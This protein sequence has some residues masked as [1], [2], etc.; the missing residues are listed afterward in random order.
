[1]T[2]ASAMGHSRLTIWGYTLYNVHRML[3]LELKVML[4]IGILGFKYSI[5]YP[6]F[7]SF[8]AIIRWAVFNTD[9]VIFL[10]K[11]PLFIIYQVG[12]ITYRPPYNFVRIAFIIYLSGGLYN[13]QTTL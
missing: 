13:V 12:C 11:S 4:E 5:V 8:Y 6:F 7:L 10:L 2:L 9:P 1:M 3:P